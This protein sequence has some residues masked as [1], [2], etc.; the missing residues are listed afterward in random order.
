M[1]YLIEIRPGEGGADAKLLVPYL[2]DIYTR[3]AEQLGASVTQEY[4][5]SL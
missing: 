4:R 5:G 1:K 3:F 2:A